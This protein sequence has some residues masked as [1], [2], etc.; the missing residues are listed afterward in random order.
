MKPLYHH[1]YIA[2]IFAQRDQQALF[3]LHRILFA[4]KADRQSP[5]YGLPE[6]LFLFIEGFIWFGVVGGRVTTAVHFSGTPHAR[7]QVMLSA[8][9][10]YA[11]PHFAATFE[12]GMHEF[13]YGDAT[14]ENEDVSDR[15]DRWM[16]QH[17]GEF[18]EVLWQLLERE[19][20]QIE[21]ILCDP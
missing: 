15:L 4:A 3:E 2:K 7:R 16:E 14:G 12:L 13:A 6:P 10:A 17:E 19:R 11:P 21:A 20:S 8:L 1:Q 18:E 5:N 9:K